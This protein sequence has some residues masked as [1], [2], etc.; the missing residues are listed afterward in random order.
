MRFD[1]IVLAHFS[2]AR[3]APAVREI[4]SVPLFTSTETTVARLRRL[5]NQAWEYDKA[6]R[7]HSQ[8]LC[9]RKRYR[10]YTGQAS[11]RTRR[12]SKH[13]VYRCFHPTRGG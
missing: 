9:E 12:P 1:A 11:C 4:V 13:S 5:V 8:W 3:V 6:A 10:E 2:T 7:S